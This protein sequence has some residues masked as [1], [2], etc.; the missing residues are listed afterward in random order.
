MRNSDT[1]TPKT[2]EHDLTLHNFT[3]SAG[4]LGIC[5]TAIGLICAVVSRSNVQTLGDDLLA[6]DSF[7]FMFTCFPSLA[8]TRTTR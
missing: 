4:L 2:R 3:L 1:L 8:A 7:L 6:V 5:L